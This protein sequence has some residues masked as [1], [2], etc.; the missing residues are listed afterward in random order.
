M[1]TQFTV[2]MVRNKYPGQ[3][4]QEARD[5]GDGGEEEPRKEA[6]QGEGNGAA[7]SPVAW[8]GG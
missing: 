5:G 3:R 2:K 6:R 1:K 4:R 7:E 8:S